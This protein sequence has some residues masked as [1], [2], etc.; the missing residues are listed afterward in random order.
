MNPFELPVAVADRATRD[1]AVARARESRVRLPTFDEIADP[2]ARRLPAATDVDPDRP[3]PANLLRVHWHNGPDRRALAP[4][5]GYVELPTALTGVPARI[6]VALG[7]RFP[8]IGAHKVLP[9]YACLVV[10]LVTGMFDPTRQRAVWP[11]TGNYCR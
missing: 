4:V 9:A 3:D 10:R 2:L 7:E 5:P 11:S 1:R 8:M 6:V